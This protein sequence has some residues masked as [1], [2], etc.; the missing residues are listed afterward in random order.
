MVPASTSGSVRLPLTATGLS[1]T[2]QV[3]AVNAYGVS[4]PAKFKTFTAEQLA[5]V[6]ISST[7]KSV[8]ILQLSD[9]HGAIEG[10]SSNAG[11]ALLTSAF[12]AERAKVP[13][14]FTLSS[15]DNIGAAPP[16][17]AAFEE[18]PTIE[19]MNLMKFDASTFGN[20]EHDRDITHVQKVIAASDFEW[21]ASNYSSLEPLKSGA[22]AAKPYILLERDGVTIGVVGANTEQTKEQ[23]FPGNLSY[24]DASGATKE[25]VISASVDGVNRAIKEARDAGASVVVALLHQG[26]QENSAGQAVGRLNEMADALKGADVV[27]GGHSHLTYSSVSAQGALIGQTTNAGQQYNRVQVCVNTSSNRA[28]GASLEVV[29]RA[30]IASLTADATAAALVKSYKDQLSSKLDVKIGQVNGIFAQGGSPQVQRAGEAAIGN[31]T[32]DALRQKYG[33]DFAFINGGGIRDKFP[34]SSY[35]PAD[36]TLNRPGTDKVAP[37]DVTLGDA[38]AVYPFGNTVGVT[39]VTG[40]N[41]WAALE[42]GVSRW[43][44]DGRFPQISGF[45]FTFDTS[46]PVGSRVQEVTKSN[47]Q[48]I[49]KDSTIYSIAVPDFMI[50]GGDGYVGVFSPSKAKLRDL[51]VDVFVEAVKAGSTGG[52]TLEIPALDGRIKKL[53]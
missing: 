11:A 50:Y 7:L 49:A 35:T 36:R 16:I 21:V 45:K 24:R 38:I 37:Y 3:H 42:N 29:R 40:E 8:Q 20:H 5:N 47:G 27:F 10:S 18:L 31:F 14:T 41:L 32:A 12:A 26:W 34:A 6:N 33:T 48:A 22:K 46:K 17:S 51:L 23:I 39:E 53:N 4:A 13:A 28:R 52:K 44:G 1:V 25:L 19:A 30:D 2:P 43:P 15:G 9:F